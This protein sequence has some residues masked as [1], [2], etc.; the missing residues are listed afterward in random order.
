MTTTATCK[1]CGRSITRENGAWIDINA[2]GDDA[3]WRETCDSHDT[4][5]A[6]HEP[7]YRSAAHTCRRLTEKQ[8][9]L[10]DA[11]SDNKWSGGL[12]LANAC[13]TSTHGVH[14][15]AA[16]LVRKGLV[17]RSVSHGHTVYRLPK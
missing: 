7:A 6:E 16:S 8:K 12:E 15:T 9:K 10:L 11:L 13:Q 2:T 3:M 4:F 17:D 1:H 14:R 5:T